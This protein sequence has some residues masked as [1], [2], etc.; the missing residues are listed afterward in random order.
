[1]NNKSELKQI[2]TSQL[3]RYTYMVSGFLL[4]ALGVL[5]AFLPLLPTTIFLLLASACFMK[6]SQRANNWLKNNRLLGAYLRNYQDKSGLTIASKIT[7]I[8]ILWISIIIS[9]F[10]FTES[11]AIRILLLLIACGVTIHLLMIKTAR[12]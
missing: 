12:G 9:A 7:H 8:A 10:V 2:K 11:T 6:S 4:V 3:A 5:G 1:M